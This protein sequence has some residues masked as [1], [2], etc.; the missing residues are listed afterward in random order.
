MPR[1]PGEPARDQAGGTLRAEPLLAIANATTGYGRT[2]VVRGITMTVAT[3]QVVA[4]VG[5]N[6]SGKSTTLRMISGLLPAM[7]GTIS[8]GGADISRLPA[9]ERSAL[10]ICHITDSRAI[11][12]GLTVE[13][14]IRL[15][16]GGNRRAA[17]EAVEHTAEIFPR[18]ADRRRQMAGTLSGGE[19]QMLA[20]TRAYVTKPRLLLLDEL[21]MGLAPIVIDEIYEAITR[22][23]AE[24]LATLIV[25]QYIKRILPL[26]E[27]VYAMSRGEISVSGA[28]A[29]VEIADLVQ[30][31]LTADGPGA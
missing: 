22:L 29:D 14:N 2:V 7:S 18:L 24:G 1:P 15:H 9:H 11:F 6:G 19:Q 21:S 26:A 8:L 17:R 31:Y 3:G 30:G 16:V 13:E 23:A 4:L 27:T 20:L 28:V 5:V 12:P 25:E 10:G